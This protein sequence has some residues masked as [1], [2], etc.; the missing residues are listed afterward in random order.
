MSNNET[1][2]ID[3]SSFKTTNGVIYLSEVDHEF[4]SLYI[5][6][7]EKES[8]VLSDDEVRLLPKTNSGHKLHREWNL[9]K[10]TTNRFLAYLAGKDVNNGLDIGCGNGWFTAEI[11]KMK[12]NSRVVGV[13]INVIELEQA[14]RVFSSKNINFL[15]H[16]IFKDSFVFNNKFDLI[17][18][19]ASVQYFPDFEILID[20]LKEF[21]IP[22]G[23]I[24]VLD[25]PFY[26]ANKTKE[27]KERTR[28]YYKSLGN[29]KLSN[30]YFHHCIK[31]AEY[32]EVL[33]SPKI[34]GKNPLFKAASSPF[35]WLKYTKDNQDN[36]VEK[37]FSKIAKEYEDLEQKSTLIQYK[38]KQIRGHLLSRLQDESSILEINCGSGLDALYF[39][40]KGHKVL[41]T[42]IAEGML[43]E[44]DTKIL[45]N[46]LQGTLSMKKL[47]FADLSQLEQ[48][49]FDCL[50]SSFGGLN[51]VDSSLLN[52][53]LQDAGSIIRHGGIITLVI[54]PKITMYEWHNIFKGKKSAFRRLK[55]GGVMANVEG[56]KVRTF[57]HSAR[58]VSKLL[59]KNFEEIRVENIFT[60]GPSGSSYN[61]PVNHRRVFSLLTKFD[62]FCN[63]T[64][65]LK[66]FG[67]YYIISAKRK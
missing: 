49:K 47:S 57:Y 38:R 37:G 15:Y 46:N 24:H 66:G 7:R 51:C 42:D 14:A 45:A 35:L 53:V 58:H 6:V 18:L 63:K 9:R 30:Y 21:L 67:D 40:K 59:N 22:N 60:I 5:D 10:K 33:Y 17:T 44:V 55:K 20:K 16:D 43:K 39:A 23:E 31:S 11:A 13:D 34:R 29:E 27:A 36:S 26:A 4:E 2:I 54:M 25:S 50:Y 64:S 8:R 56:E 62:N 32:F 48:N 52:K 1:Q 28:L 3:F 19:N 12:P 65:F 41:A 61:F